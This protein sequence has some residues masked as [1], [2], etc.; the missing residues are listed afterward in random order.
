MRSKEKNLIMRRKHI[1]GT[2]IMEDHGVLDFYF[3]F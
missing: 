2:A 3:S 1:C